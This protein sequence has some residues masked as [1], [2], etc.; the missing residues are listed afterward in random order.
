M[1]ITVI[2][3]PSLAEK[4]I[5]WFYSGRKQ[6]Y[7]KSTLDVF[8]GDDHIDCTPQFQTAFDYAASFT[9]EI[10]LPEGDYRH[11]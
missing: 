3:Y 6:K 7:C 5:A 4:T 1:K 9:S 8:I 2:T 10:Y 11:L